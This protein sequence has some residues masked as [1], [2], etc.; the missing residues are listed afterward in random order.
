[1][2]SKAKCEPLLRGKKHH[3]EGSKEESFSFWW[4]KKW[5]FHG[6]GMVEVTRNQK[7]L[8]RG[9]K[10]QVAERRAAFIRW[11]GISYLWTCERSHTYTEVCLFAGSCVCVCAQVYKTK[12]AHVLERAL[13]SCASPGLISLGQIPMVSVTGSLRTCPHILTHLINLL[14]SAVNTS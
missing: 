13:G 4:Q 14:S 1:M 12:T 10:S 11:R 2:H 3:Q 9:K 8:G 7:R 5:S 6:R